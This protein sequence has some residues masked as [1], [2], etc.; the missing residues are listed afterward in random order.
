M[1]MFIVGLV[2]VLSGATWLLLAL[3]NALEKK[4]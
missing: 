4:R 3:V 1:E 2:V